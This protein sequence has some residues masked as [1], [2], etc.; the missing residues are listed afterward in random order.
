MNV[1]VTGGT[2]FIGT[3]LVERL[4]ALGHSVRVLSRHPERA[5]LPPGASAFRFDGQSPPAPEALAG[6]ERIFHLAGESIAGRFTE[7]HK[8]RVL[9]SRVA[10]T[11]AI[12]QAAR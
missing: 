1:A 9:D 3:P 8:R 10:G 5:R 4:C 7:G 6:V 2:G 11:R 12:V